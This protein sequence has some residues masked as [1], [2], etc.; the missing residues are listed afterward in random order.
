MGGTLGVDSAPGRGSMFSFAIPL[1]VLASDHAPTEPARLAP[2]GYDGPRRRLLVVDDVAVN[3]AVLIELLSPLGF[4]LRE[5]ASGEEA[6]AALADFAPD[7][8]FLDLRMPGMDGLELARRIGERA[9]GRPRP[10]LIA[11]SASVLSFNRAQ[12]LE[13]GCDDFLPKPFREADLL[14][15]LAMHLAVAWQYPV[16]AEGPRDSASPGIATADE[17]APVLAAA[18]RG[19]IAALRRTLEELRSRY[20]TDSRVRELDRLVATY[21]LEKIREQLADFELPS[22][23]NG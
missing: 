16:P 13:A 19:E 14:A 3:R 6:L 9:H 18:R 20:P 4:V 8:V 2:V 21:Q 10:A 12:A 7:L 5:A 22:E 11:L 17:L 23:R 15:K 1:E